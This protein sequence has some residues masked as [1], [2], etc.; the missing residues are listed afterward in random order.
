MKSLSIRIASLL[1][2]AIL[3]STLPAGCGSG[4]Q[5]SG[6]P[7]I[8]A[9]PK[10]D[11]IGAGIKAPLYEVR[12]RA[13]KRGP[14]AVKQEL[15]DLIEILEATEKRKDVGQPF[16]DTCKQIVEKL[17]SLQGAANK[18]AGNKTADEIGAL[19]DKLPGKADQNPTVD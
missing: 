12:A 13:K 10:E 19:A 7:D 18:E 5:K 6:R 1:L 17:K 3:L 16:K 9:M 4:G 11:L 15:T 8:D 2:L 14:A